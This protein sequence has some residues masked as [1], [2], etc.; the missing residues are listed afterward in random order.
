MCPS[1]EF[2]GKGSGQRLTDPLY[3]H[4]P[5]AKAARPGACFSSFPNIHGLHVDVIETTPL[6]DAWKPYI[7]SCRYYISFSDNGY[8]ELAGAKCR[9]IDAAGALQART[10]ALKAPQPASSIRIRLLF[11]EVR[12]QSL[13]LIPRSNTSMYALSLGRIQSLRVAL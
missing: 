3:T 7:L 1:Q 9:Y 5:C 8:G 6:V 13:W 11:L 4:S 10:K 12:P 2:K